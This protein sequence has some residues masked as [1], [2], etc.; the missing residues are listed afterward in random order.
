MELTRHLGEHDVLAPGTCTVRTAVDG[1]YRETLLLGQIDLLRIEALQ[2]GHVASQ[3]GERYKGVDLIGKQ[4]GLLFVDALLVGA[5]LDKEVGAG[6]VA[7][8]IAHLAAIIVVLALTAAATLGRSGNL[9]GEGIRGDALAIDHHVG[10]RDGKRA[11][12]RGTDDISIGDRRGGAR[13][14]VDHLIARLHGAVRS[15]EH[16]E[17]LRDVA[18][19]EITDILRIDRIRQT[20]L[21]THR[22]M[23]RRRTCQRL[24]KQTKR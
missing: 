10:R 6:D 23:R 2:V 17:F 14:A 19:T 5:D 7:A 16:V 8:C 18:S 24:R 9:D 15:Y 11:V 20:E 22:H 4:D 13:V 3:L 21:L 12:L 1:L